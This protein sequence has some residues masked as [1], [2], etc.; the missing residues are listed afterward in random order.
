MVPQPLVRNDSSL[1]RYTRFVS[2]VSLALPPRAKNPA[3][4]VA[5]G[6]TALTDP[7]VM[8]DGQVITG[9]VVSIK[10]MICA[11][12]ARLVQSSVAVHVRRKT[13]TA[14]QVAGNTSSTNV[15]VR[16]VSPV[17]EAVGSP[18]TGTAPVTHWLV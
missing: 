3:R 17:S 1:H 5:Q 4:L 16:F 12:E 9:G 18:N 13:R 6:G 7:T 10:V 14:G 2:P 15:I 11:H 8:F